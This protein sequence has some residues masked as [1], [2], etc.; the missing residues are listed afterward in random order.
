MYA[1][2]KT[3]KSLCYIS[4]SDE[5]NIRFAHSFTS[6]TMLRLPAVPFFKLSSVF[7]ILIY[8]LNK[9]MFF[10][11]SLPIVSISA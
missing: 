3:F 8:F 10:P 11:E 7:I 9:A 5:P 6:S 4:S 2:T 1:N